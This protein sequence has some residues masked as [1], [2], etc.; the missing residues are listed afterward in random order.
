MKLGIDFKTFFCRFK[1]NLLFSLFFG[2]LFFYGA[3]LGILSCAPSGGTI[4]ANGFDGFI[5]AGYVYF[6]GMPEHLSVILE[7]SGFLGIFYFLLLLPVT[8]ELCSFG[9]H[10]HLVL[11]LGLFG[12]VYY[13][14]II[15]LLVRLI[16]LARSKLKDIWGRG[17]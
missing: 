10:G 17:I 13:N 2:I 15:I 11:I 9:I 1:Y 16:A 6:Q 8:G 14:T 3:T 4:W 7:R 5:Q 12:A